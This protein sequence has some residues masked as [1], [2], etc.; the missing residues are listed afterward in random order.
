MSEIIFNNGEKLSFA[1]WTP[2]IFLNS[3]AS[4][5]EKEEI[6]EKK[7]KSKVSDASHVSRQTIKNTRHTKPYELPV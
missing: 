4:T 6:H 3:E 2:L 5:E 7:Q 1:E